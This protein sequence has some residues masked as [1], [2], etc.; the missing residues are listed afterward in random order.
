LVQGPIRWDLPESRPG[1]SG[2]QIAEGIETQ[3]E[4]R[5]V[6]PYAVL[7]EEMLQFPK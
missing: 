7:I 3:S 5:L 2:V 4:D 6:I 1:K